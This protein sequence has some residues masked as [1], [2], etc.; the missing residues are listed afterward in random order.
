MQKKKKFHINKSSEWV[1]DQLIEDKIKERNEN[2]INI[3]V[4]FWTKFFVI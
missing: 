3:K 2:Y 1:D 4:R